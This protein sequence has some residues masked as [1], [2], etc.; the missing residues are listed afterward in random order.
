VDQPRL[1]VAVCSNRLPDQI[2]PT[3]EEVATQIREAPGT[4]GALVASGVDDEREAA[5]A[6]LATRF[7]IRFHRAGAGLSVARNA[8]LA[9]AGDADVIAYLDDDAIPAAGWLEHLAAHW[10][11]APDEL[12]CV[13]G[14][15]DPLWVDP[16]PPWMSERV[17]IVFSLLDRGEG[18]VPLRPGIED[19]WGANVSFRVDALRSVG[20]F[21]QALGTVGGIP[22]FG[23]ET[24]VQLRLARA[25]H[26]GIYVGD[27]RVKHAVTAERMRLR[28]VARRRFYAGAGMRAAGQWSVGAGLARLGAGLAELPI[29]AM[30]RRP[31]DVAAAIARAAAG[32]GV[33]A[34]PLVRRSLMRHRRE[35]R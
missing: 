16:P 14:A 11:A 18:V 22:F 30:R 8:A 13:G 32:A 33:L 20:G 4:V 17:H 23:E 12:A 34:E 28:E 15:I 6:S 3:L 25:G 26:R 31:R 5:L 24:E 35:A 2:A 1:I 27:V 10:A 21:D 7:G 9:F 19:A 29:S